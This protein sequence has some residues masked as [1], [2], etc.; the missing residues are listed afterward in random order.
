M[1][2]N[3]DYI[4]FILSKLKIMKRVHHLFAGEKLLI[5]NEN[6]LIINTKVD[7]TTE[8][9]FLYVSIDNENFKF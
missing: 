9:L 1:D 6:I 4:D 8:N 3:R 2:I 5:F 7:I